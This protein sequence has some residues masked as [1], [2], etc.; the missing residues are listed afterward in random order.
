MYRCTK[1]E[2]GTG[3]Y[4]FLGK[5][6][7]AP[8]L[9]VLDDRISNC[10]ITAAVIAD[11]AGCTSQGAAKGNAFPAPESRRY[12]ISV[13]LEHH[14]VG[15][16]RWVS[17]MD[18]RERE[19]PPPGSSGAMWGA[20]RPAHSVGKRHSGPSNRYEKPKRK[21]ALSIG[22]PN[23]SRHK[24]VGLQETTAN[25]QGKNGVVLIQSLLCRLRRQG[26]LRTLLLRWKCFGL[27]TKKKR[28]KR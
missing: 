8:P 6:G 11:V 21:H 19:M 7:S 10:N 25:L 9:K 5:C 24:R 23:L 16:L 22:N 14:C 20:A 17:G 2:G 12:H 28:K 27:C 18:H 15:C 1:G 13:A 3:R 4:T 26:L